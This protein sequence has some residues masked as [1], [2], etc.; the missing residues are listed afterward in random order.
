MRLSRLLT[1]LP[2]EPEP[3]EE[4]LLYTCAAGQ[5][6][7]TVAFHIIFPTFTRKSPGT[8]RNVT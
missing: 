6:A 3:S 1:A 2:L 5:F 7:F 4:G 8:V